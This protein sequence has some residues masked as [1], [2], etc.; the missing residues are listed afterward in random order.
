MV[1]GEKERSERKQQHVLYYSL[2]VNGQN[3]LTKSMSVA[4]KIHQF[5]SN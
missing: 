3:H 2:Y 1:A 4:N 5:K